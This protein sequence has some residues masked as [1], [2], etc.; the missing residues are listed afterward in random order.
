MLL[1][2]RHEA[3]AQRLGVHR[4]TISHRLSKISDLTGLDLSTHDDRL[5][6]DLSLYVYRLTSGLGGYMQRCANRRGTFSFARF[7]GLGGCITG[8]GTGHRSP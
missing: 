6:A 2:L 7:C 3:A 1:S 8:I 4:K 5:V